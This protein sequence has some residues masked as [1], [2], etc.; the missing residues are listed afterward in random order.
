MAINRIHPDLV[1]G[2]AIVGTNKAGADSGGTSG[3]VIQLNSSNKVATGYLDTGTTNGK[4]V[5]LDASGDVPTARIDT[6][7]GANQV[8]QLTSDP[9][10]PAVD[11]SLL[12]NVIESLPVGMPLQIKTTLLTT[13]PSDTV[14]DTETVG[15]STFYRKKIT[16]FAQSITPVRASSTFKIEVMWAGSLSNNYATNSDLGLYIEQEVDTGGDQTLSYLQAPTTGN[17]PPVIAPITI[18]N[19]STATSHIDDV[20]YSCNFIYIATPSYDLTETIKFSVGA[21]TVNSGQ[22][23][24]TNRAIDDSDANTKPRAVSSIVVTEIRGA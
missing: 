24:N 3:Q 14:D 7:T 10:L 18:T 23:L 8:V 9:K 20:I 1:E 2:T 4:L 16:G 13:T 12:T 19:P 15:T 21:K 22:T 6:G 17:R 5:L 11:G